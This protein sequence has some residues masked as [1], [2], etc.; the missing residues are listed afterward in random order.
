[1]KRSICFNDAEIVFK[2]SLP[3]FSNTLTL[4]TEQIMTMQLMT[5]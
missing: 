4:L 3:C 2:M 5:L 1:M